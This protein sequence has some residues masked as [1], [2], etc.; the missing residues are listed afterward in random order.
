MRKRSL[1]TILLILIISSC[2]KDPTPTSLVGKW[3][4]TKVYGNDY[5][6]G[7]AY[8]KP[9]N[10][11]IKVKFTSDNK[12]Y[13]KEE[14]DPDFVLNGTYTL[15]GNDAIEIT[16]SIDTSNTY[17]LNYHFESGGYMVWGF[18]STEDLQQEKFR[19]YE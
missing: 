2:S 6:G 19:L 3:V 14:T 4:Q 9:G 1:A 12:Y 11:N 16:S 17:T 10:L 13:R 7:P 8:W 15:I 5:W 18:F